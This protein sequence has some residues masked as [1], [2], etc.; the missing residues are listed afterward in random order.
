MG[1]LAILACGGALPVR[2]A[3][4]HPDAMVITLEGIPSELEARSDRHRLEKIGGLFSAMKA[5]GV[6]RMVFAG[7]LARPG[8]DPGQ[9]DGMMT[10]IAPRLMAAIPQG[11]DALL[12]TVIAIFE[13]QGFAVLGAHELL[14]ELVA[15]DGFAHGPALDEADLRDAARAGEI[16]RTLGPLDLGQGCVVAG[17]QCLGIETVQ[18][19]DA[20]LRFVGETDPKFRRGH[21]GVF[22]KAPKPGQ[23]LR[24][25]M[26]VIGP[27][28]IDGIADAGLAGVVI[29][30][31]RVMILDRDEVLRRAGA[32][33]VF[34]LARDLA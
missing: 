33:G 1:R 16:L 4:A 10:R 20:L 3:E 6:D 31:G 9:F 27:G 2:L 24:I 34:I 17:G 19:T 14:P 21:K 13:E 18:G 15:E 8:F 22:V 29:A 5:A 26:P 23:D 12:R 30:P 32:T 28:T 25:D 11:D 7:A